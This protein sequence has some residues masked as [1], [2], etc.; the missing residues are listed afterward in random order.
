[1][2]AAVA[3]EPPPR[4]EELTADQ[5]AKLKKVTMARRFCV[6]FIALLPF[7]YLSCIDAVLASRKSNIRVPTLFLISEREQD[8]NVERR[9]VQLTVISLG[10]GIS[11]LIMTAAQIGMESL[12]FKFVFVFD[13]VAALQLAMIAMWDVMVMFVAN[14]MGHRRTDSCIRVFCVALTKAPMIA[15]AGLFVIC[16][17]VLFILTFLCWQV[18][19]CEICPQNS[20]DGVDAYW[21]PC[22]PPNLTTFATNLTTSVN[23]TT[24]LREMK[25][26]CIWSYAIGQETEFGA[27]IRESE[28]GAGSAAVM[29]EPF[30]DGFC[31][32]S[33]G[34]IVFGVMLIPTLI[35]LYA[36]C[37]AGKLYLLVKSNKAIIRGE[38][39]GAGGTV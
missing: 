30:F 20:G 14:S 22:V 29:S 6:A 34:Y 4:V 10:L 26:A 3:P 7:T 5:R 35:F 39:G 13:C 25:E 16:D 36:D 21:R 28:L 17:F 11:G 12:D 38:A 1:M 15:V 33:A 8:I 27:A 18:Q 31:E 23:E 19:N 24:L 32:D 37:K 2:V 9:G